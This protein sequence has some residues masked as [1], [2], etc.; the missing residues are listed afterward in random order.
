[1]E[2]NGTAGDPGGVDDLLHLQ[3]LDGD[4]DGWSVAEQ[5]KPHALILLWISVLA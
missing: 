2:D 4:E 1:M 3:V 5:L